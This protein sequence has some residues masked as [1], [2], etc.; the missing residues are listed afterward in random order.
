MKLSSYSV[1]GDIKKGYKFAYFPTK[2]RCQQTQKG[3][4]IWFEKYYEYAQFISGYLGW[5]IYRYIN[6]DPD[7]VK[8]ILERHR[9][10]LK[11]E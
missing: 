2:V 7:R 11:E 3:Y 6:Y 8:K 10:S 4:W 1:P 9:K 5:D